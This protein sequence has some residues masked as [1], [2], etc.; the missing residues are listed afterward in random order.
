MSLLYK[1]LPGPGKK[2]RWT[3]A[4][5]TKPDSL[6]LVLVP[7]MGEK[8]L[9]HESHPLTSTKAHTR[10]YQTSVETEF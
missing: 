10:T 6:S 7:H 3:K 1:A 8:E 5:A 9:T 4:Q 2:T